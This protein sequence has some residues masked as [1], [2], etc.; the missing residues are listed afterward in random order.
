M[1]ISLRRKRQSFVPHQKAGRS[2]IQEID[3][4][5]SLPD[6][7]P[8]FIPPMQAKLVDHLPVGEQWRYELKLDGY[9]AIAI[10]M[11]SSVQLISRNEKDLSDDYPELVQ[12]LSLIPIGEGVLDGEVVVLDDSGKPSFQ[13]LQH[14]GHETRATSLL[15]LR[16]A[17]P[18]REVITLAAAGPAEEPP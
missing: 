4:L 3:S 7:A 13:A 9:R 2:P 12:T 6:V 1:A 18:R 16:S 11:A 17:E 8:G 15:R 5:S 14:L 10:K